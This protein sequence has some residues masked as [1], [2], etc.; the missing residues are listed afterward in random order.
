MLTTQ[1]D[2]VTFEIERQR[3]SATGR[4]FKAAVLTE[5]SPMWRDVVVLRD[6]HG[7]V[8]ATFSPRHD[9]EVEKFFAGVVDKAK[10]FGAHTLVAEYRSSDLWT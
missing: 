3:T 5:D 6:D 8:L 10:T 4:W 2:G 1:I 7:S 9:Q